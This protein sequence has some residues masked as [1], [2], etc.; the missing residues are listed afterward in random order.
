M[1]LLLKRSLI[2]LAICL[3]TINVGSQNDQNILEEA[4]LPEE[5]I[6]P[7][8]ANLPDS[9]KTILFVGNSLTY[10]NDLPSLV[11]TIAKEN[12]VEIVAEMI[13]YPN[14]S[15]ED[16]W[17]EGKLQR[18]IISKSYDFVIIQQGP[19]SQQNGR[20]SLLDYGAR[21]KTLCDEH[22]TKLAFFMVWPAFSN[23]QT[24]DG[25]ID[26]YSNAATVT[27][28]LLCPVGLVWKNYFSETNDYSY[29]GS[30]MF[31]PSLKG[32]QNAAKIILE[33]LFEKP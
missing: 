1:K 31:H 24:F 14:Y 32:S 25:V 11:A 23:F 15:L 16:H 2:I 28:S 7:E 20:I 30:D 17:N 9:T 8:E 12:G 21:I 18:L 10:T 5:F 19:S 29:Y 26:N 33:T 3:N 13:A 22:N 27:N 6:I 4:N